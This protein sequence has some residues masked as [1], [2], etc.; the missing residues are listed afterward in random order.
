MQSCYIF[1]S[2]KLLNYIALSIITL[3]VTYFYSAIDMMYFT[4]VHSSGLKSRAMDSF[5][6][7]QRRR[8]FQTLAFSSRHERRSY[9]NDE[10][11]WTAVSVS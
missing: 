7:C 6:R 10:R 1:H 2:M 4:P 11:R 8:L 3:F 5:I 9:S